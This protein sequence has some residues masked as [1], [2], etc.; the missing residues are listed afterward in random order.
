LS[1][2]T[3]SG[4][5]GTHHDR[6]TTIKKFK[7]ARGAGGVGVG[8]AP[9]GAGG[10]M[11]E[12]DVMLFLWGNSNASKD[13]YRKKKE[14]CSAHGAVEGRRVSGFVSLPLFR[15]FAILLYKDYS[16]I[17]STSNSKDILL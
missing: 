9:V 4:Q 5:D 10:M 13:H 6:A 15:N 3:R 7:D 1:V 12:D 2:C 16:A 14:E 8:N 11:D 17:E